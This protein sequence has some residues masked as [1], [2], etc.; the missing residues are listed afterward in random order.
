MHCT[1]GRMAA[2]FLAGVAANETVGHWWLGTFGKD[3]L[4]VKVG[5]W[6]IGAEANSV[7]MIAWPLVLVALAWYAWFRK[8]HVPAL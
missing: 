2:M 3:L 8:E 5:P 7:L 4:P 1:K 6:S